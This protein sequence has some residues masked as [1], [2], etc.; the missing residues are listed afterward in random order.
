MHCAGCH[1]KSC[2]IRIGVLWIESIDRFLTQPPAALTRC[3]D[4]WE[5]ASPIKKLQ[6]LRIRFTSDAL[7]TFTSV[8]QRK[9]FNVAF[10]HSNLPRYSALQN[11][12]SFTQS[13]KFTCPSLQ[14]IQ[15]YRTPVA[16]CPLRLVGLST[17]VQVGPA[18]IGYAAKEP[19][20]ALQFTTLECVQEFPRQNNACLT[21]PLMNPAVA[22][23]CPYFE[24]GAKKY[25]LTSFIIVQRV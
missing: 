19:S 9:Q 6:P 24:T 4:E 3:W 8:L 17:S 2:V 12:A 16:E 15:V 23:G 20:V 11:R 18:Y 22:H 14:R 5:H 7:D 13:A 1:C 10:T 21:G 25:S